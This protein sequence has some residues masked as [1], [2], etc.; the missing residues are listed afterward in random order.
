MYDL[1]E[2]ISKWR[3]GLAQ[4]QTLGKADIDELESHLREEIESLKTLKLSDEEALL[5]AAHRLG[6]PARLS[7]EFAKV[8]RSSAFRHRLFWIIV[9]I[10]GY[11]AVPFLIGVASKG[12]VVFGVSSGLEGNGLVL[13]NIVSQVLLSCIIAFLFYQVYK[14]NLD[15]LELRRLPNALKG[16]SF[17]LAAFVAGVL[18]LL[19]IVAMFVGEISSNL[20]M[21]EMVM[22]SRGFDHLAS[23]W[24]YLR[25]A[26]SMALPAI[27][28]V[29]LIKLRRSDLHEVET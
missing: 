3:A 29:L 24:G 20:R 4:S 15:G 27:L 12:W 16:R 17:I 26:W 10:V 28:V 1:N 14:M 19:G 6:S 2:Q 9:G 8:N 21:T 7:N 23:V 5:V 22:D 13:V 25:L 18:M 11:I